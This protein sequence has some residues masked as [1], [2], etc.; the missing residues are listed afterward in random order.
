MPDG[1]VI[2]GLIVVADNMPVVMMAARH[3]PPRPTVIDA[4]PFDPS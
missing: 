4:S 2:S 1:S 3:T